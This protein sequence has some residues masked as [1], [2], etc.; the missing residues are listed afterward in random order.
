MIISTITGVKLEAI[1]ACVPK[2]KI[3]NRDFAKEHFDTDLESTIKAL[4]IDERRIVISENTTS[5]DLSILAAKEIFKDKIINKSDFG[6]IIFVTL[7]PDNLMPNNAT[8]AQHLLGFDEN[9][10]AFDINHACSGYIYGL[11]N[12]ALI[13]KSMN[14]KV[15]LLDGDIN[16]HYVS[17]WDKSTALLFGDA[18]SATVVTPTGDNNEWYFTFKTDASHREALS[19]GI[20]FRD[21]LKKEHLDYCNY[22]DGSKRRFIDMSMKGE[23]VFNYVVLKVPK[24]INEFLEEIE[25][26]VTDYDNLVLHQANAF[27]LRKLARKIKFPL[28]DVPMSIGKFGNTSSV[29]IPLNICSELNNDIKSR[30]LELLLCGMGAGLSTGVASINTNECFCPGVLEV[31]L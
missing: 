14:K 23:D 16:S 20:G 4:G 9:V 26:E 17:P 30:S 6:A 15:L 22:P 5:L 31:N 10:A 7:T 8:Y 19:V 21:L 29:S 27:M 12:A 24:I 3:D 2:N 28:E 1:S 25:N 11:W 13:A 18:G